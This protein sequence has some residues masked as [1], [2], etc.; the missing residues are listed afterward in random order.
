MLIKE[1]MSEKPICLSPDTSL[2]DAAKEMEKID[3]GFI[4]VEENGQ[5]IGIVT[6]RDIAI[7][8]VSDGQDPNST[9]VKE[10]MSTEVIS[11]LE[12]DDIKKAADMMRQKQIRRLI[13]LNKNKE[14]VGILSLGDI[15]TNSEDIQLS[16]KLI[17]DISEP[18][19]YTWYF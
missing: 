4:P 14:L 8:A 19:L 16:G 3:A 1:I 13:V 9:T 11:C 2:K 7:R 17:K 15:V 18:A 10:I 12:D 6:D 5:I